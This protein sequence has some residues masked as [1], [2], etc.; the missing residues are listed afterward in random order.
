MHV[1]PAAGSLAVTAYANLFSGAVLTLYSGA[2]PA[3][4]STAITTQTPL[5][6]YTFRAPGFVGTPGS[7]I[8]AA[9]L[10]TALGSPVGNGVAT[11]ARAVLSAAPWVTATSYARGA[12]VTSGSNLYVCIVPGVSET[13]PTAVA[14]AIAD[15]AIYW[16]YVGPAGTLVLADYTVGA[17]GSGSDIILNAVGISIGVNVILA[18][19]SIQVQVV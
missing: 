12:L 9:S 17:G 16:D 1:N 8:L 15:W 13:A 11:W 3:S 10:V 14:Y 7:D 2:I 18:G 6:S 4:S 5:V 19:F